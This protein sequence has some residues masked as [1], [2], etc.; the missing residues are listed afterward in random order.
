V[1]AAEIVEPFASAPG[2]IG[3]S[4]LGN[5]MLSVADPVVLTCWMANGQWAKDNR[6]AV[7]AWRAALDDAIQYIQKNDKASRAVLTKWT[8]LPDEVANAVRL[9]AY[10]TQL[11]E[12]A[13]EIWIKTSLAVGAISEKLSAAGSSVD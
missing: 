11:D 9:P 3:V 13:I 6:T 7:L 4:S 12:S 8:R 5:P 10:S 1:A 2:K